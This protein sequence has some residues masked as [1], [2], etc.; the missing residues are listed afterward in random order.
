MPRKYTKEELIEMLKSRAEELGRSPKQ[1]EVKQFQTIV[2]RFGSFNKGLEAAGLTPN[3]KR[4]KKYTEA[5]LIEILQQRAEELGRSPKKR[6]IKQF[7]T[8]VNHFGT[9]NKGLEAAGLTPR[10]RRDY[11]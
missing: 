4:R 8:I 2:K 5:E 10:R 11:K 9:F 6:E 7:Q 3:K 1:K